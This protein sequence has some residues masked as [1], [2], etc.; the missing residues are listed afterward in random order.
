MADKS[1]YKNKTIIFFDYGNYTYLAERLAED[2]GTVYYYT[3]YQTS[4][5]KYQNQIVGTGLKNVIRV[6]S[7]W[8]MLPEADIIVFPDL[9]Q[10][11]LQNYLRDEGYNVFGSFGA[12]ELEILRIEAKDRLK[13]AGLPVGEYEVVHGLDELREKLKQKSDVYVKMNGYLRGQ[14]ETWHHENYDLS[15]PVL[16]EMEHS[17]GVAKNAEPFIIEKPIDCLG[18]VGWDGWIVDDKFPESI[19]CGYESKDSCYL[20]VKINYNDL[21]EPIKICNEKLKSVFEE[22]GYA[23]FYSNEIRIEKETGTPYLTDFTCRTPEPPGSIY[24]CIYTNISDII[25]GVAHGK[26]VQPEYK[27]KFGVQLIIKSDWAQDEP[28]AIYFPEEIRPFV[29]IKNHAIVDGVDYYV[30]QNTGMKEIG[31]LV[32]SS[33]ILDDAVLE[34]KYMAKKIKGYGISLD[35]DILDKAKEKIINF[36]NQSSIK[37]LT[38][39]IKK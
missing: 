24:T 36:E 17:F 32:F 3:P 23:G 2:F 12:E 7:F 16:D 35:A 29:K 8:E 27:G 26:M 30:P 22:Y 10:G 5:P 31:A 14:M 6:Y 33:E 20:G 38:R 15:K 18:E 25:W 19:M 11:D 9:F 1:N 4:F 28:Q 34:I 39:A 13:E 37:I 21:P